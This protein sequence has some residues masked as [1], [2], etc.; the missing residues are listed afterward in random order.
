MITAL[1]IFNYESYQP[2]RWHMTMIMWAV[3]TIPLIS[4][5]W[6]RKMLNTLELAGGIVHV[7]LFIVSMAVLI[8][9]GKRSTP[10][11]VFKTVTHDLSGWENPGIAWGLGLLTCTFSVVGGFNGFKPFHRYLMA[12]NY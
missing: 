9:L 2:K 11:F 4:N 7:V 5:L 8:A 3:I 1:A 12:H 6:F 10:E